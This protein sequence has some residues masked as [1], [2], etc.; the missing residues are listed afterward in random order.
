MA[1]LVSLSIASALAGGLLVAAMLAP[2][3]ALG[4][5]FLALA[6]PPV[7]I[8]VACFLVL[9]G[10]PDA[11]YGPAYEEAIRRFRATATPEQLAEWDAIAGSGD[12]EE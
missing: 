6:M 5:L 2:T 9:R 12:S 11:A 8:S 4:V 10:R 1:R 3:A 7:G